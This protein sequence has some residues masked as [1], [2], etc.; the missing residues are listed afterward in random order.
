MLSFLRERYSTTSQ[1]RELLK[2]LRKSA[3]GKY[4]PCR[5]H[6]N[7]STHR[8]QLHS[9]AEFRLRC[10]ERT[11]HNGLAAG[12]ALQWF[13]KL[14]LDGRLDLGRLGF[15]T[16]SENETLNPSQSKFRIP[17][18]RQ[19]LQ[20]SAHPLLYRTQWVP[21]DGNCMFTAFSIALG[22]KGVTA[23]V[24]RTEA[25]K[26]A[27][28]NRDFF[29]PFV[30][31]YKGGFAGW[32]KDMAKQ[33]IYGN[34]PIL[35]ALCKVYDVRLQV[36]KQTHTGLEWMEVG[37]GSISM[38]LFLFNEHYENLVSGAEVG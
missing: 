28:E 1:L 29:S 33:G 21:G 11:C 3:P 32:I 9:R 17:P 12:E 2:E 22:R 36:L 20:I 18:I 8:L 30:A 6:P 23:K 24:A 15:G 5:I 37:D 31:D 7:D 13:A 27:R 34:H 19:L 38:E 14:A 35:Q 4:I 16:T 26:Y 10:G 25:V